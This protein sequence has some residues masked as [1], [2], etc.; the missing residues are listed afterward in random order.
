MSSC[1]HKATKAYDRVVPGGDICGAAKHSVSRSP[2]RR[3]IGSTS[4]RIRGTEFMQYRRRANGLLRLD[5]G[6]LDDWPPFLDL[7]LLQS[8]ERFGR[9]LLAR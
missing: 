7:G 5:V 8:G 2:R 1:G 9:L 6:R 4:R 3:S